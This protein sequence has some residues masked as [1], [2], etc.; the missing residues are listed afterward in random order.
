MS[1]HLKQLLKPALVKYCRAD[2]ARTIRR[3]KK[4][5]AGGLCPTRQISVQSEFTRGGEG[6]VLGF[7]NKSLLALYHV[8][9]IHS[10]VKQSQWRVVWNS[11]QGFHT[12]GD[13]N[14]LRAA[15]A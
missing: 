5:G 9:G 10:Q 11:R 15:H 7:N 13:R 14:D 8:V 1:R 3:R 4:L 6:T 2:S 12:K